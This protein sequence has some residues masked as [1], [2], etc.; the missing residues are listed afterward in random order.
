MNKTD[1]ITAQEW[2]QLTY[3][4]RKKLYFFARYIVAK[5]KIRKFF[6]LWTL[7]NFAIRQIRMAQ[8]NPTIVNDGATDQTDM[9]EWKRLYSL[10]TP[11]ERLET[12]LLMLTIIEARRAPTA[13]NPD[14]NGGE[15]T[16]I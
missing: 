2:A 11:E 3:W 4:R 6:Q 12:M 13:A 16:E 15:P 10:S 8:G 5:I 7:P 1:P 14:E 9:T